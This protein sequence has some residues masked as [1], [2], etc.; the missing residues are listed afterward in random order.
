MTERRG[1]AADGAADGAALRTVMREIPSE[2]EEEEA[3]HFP[4]PPLPPLAL[5]REKEAGGEWGEQR[6]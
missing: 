3:L 1:V 4:R 5:P 2:E 6:F